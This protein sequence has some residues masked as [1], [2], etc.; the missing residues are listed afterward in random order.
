MFGSVRNLPLHRLQLPQHGNVRAQDGKPKIRSYFQKNIPSKYTFNP[1]FPQI[2][3]DTV[4][5]TGTF[6]VLP[7]RGASRASVCT[8]ILN[9]FLNF[10][11]ELAKMD[12]FIRLSL[13]RWPF[14]DCG[15][16]CGVSPKL[17]ARRARLGVRGLS[18]WE[19]SVTIY[20]W[21]RFQTQSIIAICSRFGSPEGRKETV[22]LN[23]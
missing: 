21:F 7:W 6:F 4:F 15:G 9:F 16:A 19:A 8:A 12:I 18:C 11:K 5:P 1:R 23:P 13:L 3:L 2:F 22:Y 20:L 17:R 10:L 14:Q